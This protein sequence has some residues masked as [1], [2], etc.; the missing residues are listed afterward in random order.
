VTDCKGEKSPANRR[1][2]IMMKRKKKKNA[3][4]KGVILRNDWRSRMGDN[5]N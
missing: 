5:Q 2:L 3:L 4:E 1:H